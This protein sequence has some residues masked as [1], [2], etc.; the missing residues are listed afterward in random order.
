MNEERIE[1]SGFQ[2]VIKHNSKRWIYMLCFVALMLID[3][4]RGSQ[5]G[6]TWA[7]TVNMQG[8]VVGVI[9]LT[10]YRL[11]EFRK[12]GYLIY[13]IVCAVALPLSYQWWMVH[14]EAIYRD[15]LLTAVLNVWV[16]G[17][18][19]F[20]L[21]VEIHAE[22]IRNRIRITGL[23]VIGGLMLL[24]MAISVNE[25][26]W[27]IWYLVMF[28]LLSQMRMSKAQ[29]QMLADG[30]IDGILVSFFILQGLAF[31]FRPF[32]A[33]TYRYS[34]MYA[35]CNMNGLFYCIVLCAFL[36][37]LYQLR[38]KQAHKV[39]L[40]LCFVF[41]GVMYGF[42]ALTISMTAALAAVVI[43]IL[44]VLVV[45]R[46]LLQWSRGRAL[47]T[48]AGL[49]VIIVVSVPV[50]YLAVRYL[51]TILHHPIWYEGEYSEEKVHS[52]DPWDSEKYVSF[53]EYMNA[54]FGKVLP[55]THVISN[56]LGL[57]FE[58]HAIYIGDTYFSYE[59]ETVL[60]YSSLLGRLA[61]WY[62]YVVHANIMGHSNL[63]GHDIGNGYY[64]YTW[65]AQNVF[66]Q[67][68]FYYGIPAAILLVLYIIRSLINSIRQTWGGAETALIPMFLISIFLI[69]GLL[70]AVWY[71][72]QM[73]LWALFFTPLLLD[74]KDKAE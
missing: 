74:L 60:K 43:G 47:R 42:I 27:P 32:D 2:D 40:M 4:T 71:P 62:Y 15:K 18:F 5:V 35:N 53:D 70:E 34:G 56:R 24:W 31:G 63:D 23:Q 6:S 12:F 69:V 66:V 16:L 25:D 3:W 55:Y 58:V 26:V 21:C 48:V 67:F 57:S 37:R 61:T 38:K 13:S 51:P 9:L 8:I 7:W 36:V 72:G 41:A 14:Q 33:P 44:F 50:D 68:M 22:G 39:W 19:V 52:F 11:Q 1:T 10:T 20:K 59:D 30:M 65:H 28:F 54:G 29:K 45:D 64:M 46:K 73:S 49:L 17:I